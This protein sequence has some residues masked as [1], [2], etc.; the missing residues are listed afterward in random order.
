MTSSLN[1]NEKGNENI[2]HVQKITLTNT[3]QNDTVNLLKGGNHLPKNIMV[4]YYCNANVDSETLDITGKFFGGLDEAITA[5][6]VA[7]ITMAAN[8][9]V[10]VDLTSDAKGFW[11][12]TFTAGTFAAGE[13]VDITVLTWDDNVIAR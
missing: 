13:Q 8:A 1:L 6:V 11:E 12:L 3:N 5:N 7:Q 2:M 10:V 9:N 4:A